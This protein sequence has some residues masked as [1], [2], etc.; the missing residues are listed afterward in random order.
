MGCTCTK[1]FPPAAKGHIS[2]SS[3]ETAGALQKDNNGHTHILSMSPTQVQRGYQGE[4][5]NMKKHGIGAMRYPNGEVYI[6]Y[7]KD[8]KKH[9][10]GSYYHADGSVYQG[11]YTKGKRHGEGQYSNPDGSTYTGSYFDGNMDGFGIYEW[12]DGTSYTGTWKENKRHGYGCARGSDGS[13][14]DGRWENDIMIGIGVPFIDCFVDATSSVV[15][16]ECSDGV[17]CERT[18]A[19]VSLCSSEV[20]RQFSEFTT[21]LSTDCEQNANPNAQFCDRVL[22]SCSLFCNFK[23]CFSDAEA[24]Y[25]TVNADCR[26]CSAD[27]FTDNLLIY[28]RDLPE[29]ELNVVFDQVYFE[30]ICTNTD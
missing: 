21:K 15:A 19:T 11:A 4:R 12:P 1:P 23:N 17:T 13:I 8:D 14:Y 10:E 16:K 5:L 6:G 29:E 26:E 3:S 2:L 7:W 27:C 18:H 25:S 20:S 30:S 24:C 22:L 28:L 9:G